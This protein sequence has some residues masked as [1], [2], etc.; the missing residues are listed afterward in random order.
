MNVVLLG[1]ATPAVALANKLPEG[2]DVIKNVAVAPPTLHVSAPEQLTPVTCA[3]AL[4]AS[5]MLA[6]R[7]AARNFKRIA[8]SHVEKIYAQPGEKPGVHI[9]L[10][11]LVSPYDEARRMKKGSKR[12]P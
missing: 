7:V 5:A 12:S 8:S 10:E 9:I 3:C 11:R 6:R 4:A 1:A 2:T